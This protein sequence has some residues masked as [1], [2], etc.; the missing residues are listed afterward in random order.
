MAIGP[1]VEDASGASSAYSVE[2]EPSDPGGGTGGYDFKVKWDRWQR[3]RGVDSD[4]FGCRDELT[5]VKEVVENRLLQSRVGL[6]GRHQDG[7]V[8]LELVS[9][10]SDGGVVFR[11]LLF[12]VGQMSDVGSDED[13]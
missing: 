7:K 10:I 12:C 2:R 1:I 9:E 13:T 8:S 4:G 6:D 3:T 11:E 5:E